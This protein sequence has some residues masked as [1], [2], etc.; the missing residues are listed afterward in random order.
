MATAVKR[1]CGNPLQGSCDGQALTA[2]AALLGASLDIRGERI[3]RWYILASPHQE[4]RM[5]IFYQGKDIVGNPGGAHVQDR[6]LEL[7]PSL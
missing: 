2:W 7:Q 1:L 5:T 3:G 4:E 6:Y